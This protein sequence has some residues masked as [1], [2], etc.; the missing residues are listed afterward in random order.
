MQLSKLAMETLHRLAKNE[1][2]S[3]WAKLREK[4]FTPE[5]YL[6]SETLASLVSTSEAIGELRVAL[7]KEI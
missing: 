2:S 7:G 5:R 4:D 6:H 3:L 1:Q